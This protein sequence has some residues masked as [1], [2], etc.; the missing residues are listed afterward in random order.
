MYK[1][2]LVPTDGSELSKMAIHE[3]VAMAKALGS[4]VTAVTVT[5]PFHVFA[6]EPEMIVDTIEQYKKR[7]A[8][9]AKSYLD[10]A[11]NIAAASGVTCDVVHVVHEHPYK[12][13]IDTAEKRGCDAILMASHGRRGISAI[14]LGS[15]TLKVLTH[16][17]MPVIV[18]RRAHSAK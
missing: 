12:A 6:V 9:V 13:I 11:R 1:H 2:I 4:R 3:A 5:S 10:V 14:V 15:E 17:T 16:S 7:M 8:N 18:Y